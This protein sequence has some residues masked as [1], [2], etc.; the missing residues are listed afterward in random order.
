MS[1]L[2]LD[3]L[4]SANAAQCGSLGMSGIILLS[5]Y[6]ALYSYMLL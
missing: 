3:G 5:F 4:D 2:G 1:V 6:G